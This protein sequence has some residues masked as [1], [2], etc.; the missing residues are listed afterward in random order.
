MKI[1][2][3]NNHHYYI[4]FS[5][6]DYREL[7]KLNV[8]NIRKVHIFMVPGDQTCINKT[9]I[10]LF[11]QYAYLCHKRKIQSKESIFRGNINVTIHTFGDPSSK[12]RI[13]EILQRKER[14]FTI[15]NSKQFHTYVNWRN[16]MEVDAGSRTLFVK[17]YKEFTPYEY[18]KKQTDQGVYLRKCITFSAGKA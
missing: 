9:A 16:A 15:N 7:T 3:S 10:N 6:E 13:H 2:I 4:G 11:C 18:I 5:M 8:C 1:E 17:W 14:R 12:Q